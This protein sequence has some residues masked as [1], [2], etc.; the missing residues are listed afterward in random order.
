[1]SFTGDARLCLNWQIACDNAPMVDGLRY[2]AATNAPSTVVKLMSME[3]P[4][5][6]VVGQGNLGRSL[7]NNIEKRGFEVLRYSLEEPYSGARDL[8]RDCD[9][10]FVCVPT[11]TTPQGFDDRSVVDALSIV[12]RGRI[13][14][15]KSTVL[16]GTT[17]RMQKMF[18]D[19]IVVYSPEFMSAATA[20]EDVDHPIM[21]IV[22]TPLNSTRHQV[23]VRIVCSVMPTSIYQKVC[24]SEEAELIK[25]AHNIS[26]YIQVLT[27]NIMYDIARSYECDWAVIAEAVKADPLIS[28]RYSQ[29]FDK[30]GRGAGGACF[31]KDFSAFLRLYREQV[32][33]HFGVEFLS[34][35]ERKNVSLLMQTKKDL[36]Q[37]ASVYGDSP[38]LWSG[39]DWSPPSSGRVR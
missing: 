36:D 21:N 32:D 14:V 38:A 25:Y 29:P 6:G 30:N 20:D 37:V 10:V 27:F 23:A 5:I 9:I 31:L 39:G 1:M 17:A 22:G 7:A 26:G 13:G 4:K 19:I 12:G 33:D 8:I 18:P 35:A 3:R 11:P 16:P 15:I 34:A 28:S 24:R 2:S